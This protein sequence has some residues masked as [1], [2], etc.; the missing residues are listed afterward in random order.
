[1]TMPTAAQI[2]KDLA[3]PTFQAW[4]HDG[5]GYVDVSSDI[6]DIS[7]EY[8]VTSGPDD[9]VGFGIAVAPSQQIQIAREAFSRDWD[10]RPI[11]IALGFEGSNPTHF[12]GLVEGRDRDGPQGSWE[13]TGYHT[14]IQ[15]VPEIRS[16][17]LY[18]RPAF[19][20]TT[21]TSVENPD[22]SGW[23]GGLGNLVLW[24]AGGRP[25]EQ[26]GAYPGAVFYYSCETSILAPEWSW[27]DGGDGAKCLND[28]CLAAGG[29]VYQDTAGVVN[30]REPFG[31]AMGTPVITYTD[32]AS[33]KTAAARVS[34]AL[35]QYGR[36]SER[37]RTDRRV[38]DVVTCN[39]TQ[40][41][42]QGVQEI[43]SD[44]TPRLI[45]AGQSLS[46]TLDLQLP[47]Y[48]VDRVEAKA[49]TLRSSVS[50]TSSQLTISITQRHA[51]RLVITLTNTLGEALGL[52]DLKA[53]GQPLVAGEEGS[54]SYGTPAGSYP[55]A[56]KVPDSVYIQSK[57]Y[58]ERLCWMY[59]D[60]YKVPRAVRTLEGCGFDPRRQLGEIINV[61]S[62]DWGMTATP[63][64]VIGK[65]VSRTGVQ[66]DL[67]VVDVS[68]LPKSSDFYQLGGSFS[69]AAQLAY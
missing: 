64:R 52:Y 55:R 28:L 58:A 56:Y 37:V 18:R 34:G 35:A 9:G 54:A 63:H 12:L 2:E 51:Q 44:K 6:V 36:L 29:V 33:A 15:A 4:L 65:R 59:H 24:R 57:S 19:T 13:A 17:L 53:F 31:F 27:L 47:C 8:R 66:M 16:P 42:L 23:R 25:L 61:V 50:A 32:A 41:R 30:Y 7:G 67:D 11:R 3:L 10:R 1:M 14:L 49:G 69:P 60:F 43:Y 20:A 45:E 40:R 46:V 5:T 38:V 48:R 22:D 26:S 21:A 39:F 68:G 62:E